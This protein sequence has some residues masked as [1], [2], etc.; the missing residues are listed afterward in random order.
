MFDSP[1][2]VVPGAEEGWLSVNVSAALMMMGQKYIFSILIYSLI[3]ACVAI[4]L[5]GF[6]R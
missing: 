1:C 6:L 3:S 5:C 2:K 4:W